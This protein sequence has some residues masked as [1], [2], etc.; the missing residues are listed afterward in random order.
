MFCG[1]D[2]SQQ[3]IPRIQIVASYL[4]PNEL[5]EHCLRMSD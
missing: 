2:N 4:S 1:T 5:F 3:T